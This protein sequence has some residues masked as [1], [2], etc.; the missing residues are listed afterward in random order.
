M[1]LS[2]ITFLILSIQPVELIHLILA[3]SLV[4]LSLILVFAIAISM[5]HA[6]KAEFYREQ[7]ADTAVQIGGYSMCEIVSFCFSMALVYTL[8]ALVILGT[9]Y[10]IATGS[11]YCW[12]HASSGTIALAS[13]FHWRLCIYEP[14][15]RQCEDCLAQWCEGR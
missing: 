3:K 4:V 1:L 2:G 11:N 9:I 7:N 6:I 10:V 12:L 8:I 5:A 13:V 15:H 14:N